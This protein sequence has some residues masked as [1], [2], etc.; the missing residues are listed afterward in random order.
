MPFRSPGDYNHY[1]QKEVTYG[2]SPGALVAGDGFMSRTASLLTKIV[3]RRDRDMDGDG[4]TSVNTTQLG[5]ESGTFDTGE[6]DVVPS[7]NA[8]TP[9]QPDMGLFF[10]AHMGQVLTGL[11]HTTT[12]A[13]STTTAL[14]LVAG[15][16]AAGG[17][18]VGQMVAVN[19]SAAFGW[20]VREVTIVAGEVVTLDR[21]LSAAPAAGRAVNTGIT[22]RIDGDVAIAL[23]LWEFLGQG[24]NFRHIGPGSHPTEMKLGCD[25][26]QSAPVVTCQ[27]SGPTQK[28]DPQT[29]TAYVAPTTAGLPLIPTAT[30]IWIGA[31]GAL[32]VTSVEITSNDGIE[33]RNNECR[34]SL[35]REPSRD[36]T[37]AQTR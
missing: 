1:V 2:V 10:E 3:E 8:T 24:N 26:T 27:F 23:H 15:G 6:C 30:K 11:A 7:G 16:V 32:C 4:L 12:D 20:E 33:A 9:T 22:Y 17:I 19:V 5:R 13:G 18:A 21:A 29:A 35:K 25:F 34:S 36:T 37:T 31:T 28:V 14:T